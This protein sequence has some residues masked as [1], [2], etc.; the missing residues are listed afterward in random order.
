[1]DPSIRSQSRFHTQQS[2]AKT[3]QLKAHDIPQTIT[4]DFPPLPVGSENFTIQNTVGYT[5]ASAILIIS[6]YG[7][8]KS[9]RKIK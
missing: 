1:M 8:L 5:L 9:Y 7:L 2:S 6:V 4:T 3:I